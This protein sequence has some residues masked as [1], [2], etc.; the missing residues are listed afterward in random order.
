MRSAIVE[1]PVVN[2]GSPQPDVLW[3]NPDQVAYVREGL[4][5]GAVMMNSTYSR[6]MRGPSSYVRIDGVDWDV[7][8]AVQKVLEYLLAAGTE[9]APASYAHALL[10]GIRVATLATS[11]SAA[12]AAPAP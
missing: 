11:R 2:L 9:V 4:A 3:I 7:A 8:A 10:E 12:V 1:L 5:E 6:S